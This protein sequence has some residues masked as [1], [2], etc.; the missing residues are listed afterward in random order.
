MSGI[1]LSSKQ[2]TS[3]S[4]G[5]LQ[6]VTKSGEAGLNKPKR[7]LKVLFSMMDKCV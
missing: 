5:C 3:K 7:Q 1:K 2:H 6:L 4:G